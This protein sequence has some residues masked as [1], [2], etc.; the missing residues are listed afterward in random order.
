MA[1]AVYQTMRAVHEFTQ[2]EVAIDIESWV[3]VGASK[4]GWTTFIVGAG[5]CEKCAKISGIVPLVPIVP[6]LTGNLHRM[7]QAYG[8]FT[9]A[10]KP[11]MDIGLIEVLDSQIWYN[12]SLDIDPIHYGERLAEIPK[13]VI[14]SSDDEFMMMDQ[15][16]IWFKNLTGEVHLVIAPNSEHSMIT[17]IYGVISSAGVFIRSVMAGKTQRPNF[18]WTHDDRTGV[19]TVDTS[20]GQKP[21]SVMLRHTET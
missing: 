7:W 2:Q 1:K 20:K 9:F 16:D 6:D 18:T 19:I 21:T 5:R 8:G 4:R 3:V 10:F 17:N 14:V 15:T 13:M 12:G 11:Y